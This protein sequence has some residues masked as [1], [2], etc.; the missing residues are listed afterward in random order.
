[1]NKELQEWV[2]A[3]FTDQQ[4][5]ELAEWFQDLRIEQ[6]FFLKESY[7]AMLKQCARECDH[8]YVH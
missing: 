7:E 2:K 8:T 6:A 1:M 3:E 4:I 5:N